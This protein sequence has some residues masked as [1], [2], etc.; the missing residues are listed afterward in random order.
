MDR[1]THRAKALVRDGIDQ[2]L[3]RLGFSQSPMRITADAEAYWTSGQGETWAA[4]SHWH[5]GLAENDWHVIGTEHW[6]L[7]QTFARAVG[8][9]GPLKRIVD[10]GC[11][12]GANAVAFAPHCAEYIGA[13]IVPASVREC[14]DQVAMRCD[15]PFKGI[16]IDTA[17][18]E[19]SARDIPK[20][21]L[22]ICF[23]VFEV[24]PT[25][26]YGLRIL[27]IAANLLEP[28]GYAIVQIKYRSGWRSASRGRRY[29]SS[30]A[31]TMTSYRIEEF[32]NAALR[33]G[34]RPQL[35]HLVP[36]NALDERYAYFLLAAPQ[37]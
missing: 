9:D 23:Y 16:V 2:A 37:S 5:D 24:V 10:W 28:S 8:A 31:A 4:N 34:L 17:Q 26:E 22:F 29:K 7:W 6:S 21:D 11:G 30:T 36:R 13:D 27:K 12:G 20:C 15:T 18:P 19:I 33:C 3:T 32:W 35:I 25:P 14:E 1:G